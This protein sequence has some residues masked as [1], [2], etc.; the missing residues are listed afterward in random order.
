MNFGGHPNTTTLENDVALFF[1]AHHSH[2]T[3]PET[4]LVGI[5]LTNFTHMCLEMCRIMLPAAVFI[6]LSIRNI[7]HAYQQK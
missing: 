4:A 2:I 3:Q 5:A 7:S 1:K 6:L